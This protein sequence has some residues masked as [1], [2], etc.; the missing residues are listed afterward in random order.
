[1]RL[2]ALLSV[3]AGRCDAV[4]DDDDCAGD[5]EALDRRAC[6]GSRRR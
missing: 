2:V 4:A 5:A 3:D 1:M 6:S